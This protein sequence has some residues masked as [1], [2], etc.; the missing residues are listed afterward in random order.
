MH[1][2]SYRCIQ[3]HADAYTHTHTNTYVLYIYI[4]KYTHTHTSSYTHIYTHIHL[5]P[6]RHIYNHTHIYIHIYIY[7]YTHTHTCTHTCTHTNTHIYAHIHTDKRRYPLVF[8]NRFELVKRMSWPPFPISSLKTGLICHGIWGDRC[9]HLCGICAEL[10]LLGHSLLGRVRSYPEPNCWSTEVC[11]GR[12]LYC[13]GNHH[14]YDFYYCHSG[15]SLV[16]SSIVLHWW[17]GDSRGLHQSFLLPDLASGVVWP[18]HWPQ[19]FLVSP[20]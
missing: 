3:M 15:A 11:P 8:S 19:W 20:H 13:W 5:H 9:S 7:K 12:V 14:H 4:Y 10:V 17:R 6:H 1:T 16:F 18:Q 2:D